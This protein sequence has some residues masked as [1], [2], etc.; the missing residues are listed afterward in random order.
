MQASCVFQLLFSPD[1]WVRLELL[2]LGRRRGRLSSTGGI[3]SGIPRQ[4]EHSGKAGKNGLS[5]MC[6][7][8]SAPVFGCGEDSVSLP[9]VG[10]GWP[11][12]PAEGESFHAS[13]H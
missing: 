8:N 11:L 7:L 2:K 3:A 5:C 13:V 9:A 6:N 1:V 4:A 10:V 12:L